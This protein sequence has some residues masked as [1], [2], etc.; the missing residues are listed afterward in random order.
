METLQEYE[1]SKRLQRDNKLNAVRGS[2]DFKFVMESALQL[3][4]AAEEVKDMQQEMQAA[5]RNVRD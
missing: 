1:D 5:V 3:I 2:K 4:E